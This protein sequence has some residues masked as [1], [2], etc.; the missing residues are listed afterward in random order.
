MDKTLFYERHTPGRHG[1]SDHFPDRACGCHAH[2]LTRAERYYMA[3]PGEFTQANF[4]GAAEKISRGFFLLI[5]SV[6]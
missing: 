3:V 6:C 1:L 5:D 4:W 2:K